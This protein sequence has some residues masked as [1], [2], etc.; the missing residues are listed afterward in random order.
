LS[1]VWLTGHENMTPPQFSE[2]VEQPSSEA[3][4]TPS[5]N[6]NPTK[7]TTNEKHGS[8][9][10]AQSNDDNSKYKKFAC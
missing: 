3:Q 10:D 7:D 5:A 9:S 2:V 1:F 8:T 6:V 4:V